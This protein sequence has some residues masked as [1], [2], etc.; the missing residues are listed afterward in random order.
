M[1]ARIYVSIAWLVL[2]FG[3]VALA[4]CACAPA[5]DYVTSSGVAVYDPARLSSADEIQQWLDLTASLA[6]ADDSRVRDFAEIYDG[7][8]LTIDPDEE[9]V[10]S[11]CSE[12]EIGC[13]IGSEK[14]ILIAWRPCGQVW[15]APAT[16]A[17]EVG[18]LLGYH[19]D[20]R[21]Y[22]EPWFFGPTNQPMSRV[23][24]NAVCPRL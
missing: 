13:A 17:H 16:L 20:A 3:P 11:V 5:P 15:S 14:S 18:H 19:H 7:A 24:E 9:Y 8:T 21:G 23:V 6:P 12:G 2:R 22:G 4:L 1:K 10:A